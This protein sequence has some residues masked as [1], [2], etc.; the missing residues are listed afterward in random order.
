MK[1]SKTTSLGIYYAFHRASA[2]LSQS[3]DKEIGRVFAEHKDK[4]AIV[5]D[6]KIYLNLT[7]ASEKRSIH[8]SFKIPSVGVS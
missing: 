6:K 3:A 8:R 2:I 5:G 7:R 4:I 1:N